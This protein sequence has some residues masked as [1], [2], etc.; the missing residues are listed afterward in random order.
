MSPSSRRLLDQVA[1]ISDVHGNVSAL[2]AVL[3]D[4]E[5]RGIER[6]INLGDVVGKGPR[7]AQ[8]IKLSRERCEVTVRGNWDTVIARNAE[9]PFEH[10]QWVRDELDDDEIGSTEKIIKTIAAAPDGTSWVV[11]T[12]LNL[13]NRLRQQFPK[14]RIAF[15][16][17][18]VCY[19]T[20]MNRIDLPHLVW[21]LES[22]VDGR[23]VNPI[24]VDSDVA[25]WSRI[26]LDQ[27]LALPGETAKD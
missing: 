9:L 4:I 19:C 26:A 3:D 15:L 1:V 22:L 25:H 10:G 6:V 27:M 16:E 7:G 13:V 23:V 11:G 14:Q 18:N 24:R 17:K 2:T 20:T 21:A 5:A 8:S 12:E